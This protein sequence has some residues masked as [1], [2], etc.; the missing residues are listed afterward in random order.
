MTSGVRY[1]RGIVHLVEQLLFHCRGRDAAAGIRKFGDDRAAVGRHFGDRVAAIGQ[2]GHVL[3][4]GIGEIAAG[5]LH[6]A[7]HQMADQGACAEQRHIGLRPSRSG[8]ISGARYIDGS[9]SRPPMMTSAPTRKRREDGVDAE[10]GVHADDR[11][12]DID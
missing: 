6:A 5:D 7:F 9:A 11:H 2:I 10:I 12:A 4:A 3:D 8:A 1:A